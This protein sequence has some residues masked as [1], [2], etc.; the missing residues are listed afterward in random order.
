[1]KTNRQQQLWAAACE[2]H[3]ELFQSLFKPA[4]VHDYYQGATLLHAV[5][6]GEK[7]I[8]IP[9]GL[10]PSI[11]RDEA[12]LHNHA[13]IARILL[14]NG[15]NIYAIGKAPGVPVDNWYI[16]GLTPYAMTHRSLTI[17]GRL[18]VTFFKVSGIEEF[19]ALYNPV[20]TTKVIDAFITAHST[21]SRCAVM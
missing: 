5:I 13:E 19:D 15:A 14:E 21:K 9:L 1:M 2:G 7:A 16:N 11:V 18:A 6:R 12:A 17:T 10:D 8:G 20:E 4:D 3:L